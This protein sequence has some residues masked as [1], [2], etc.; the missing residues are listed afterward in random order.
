MRLAQVEFGKSGTTT[1]IHKGVF[2]IDFGDGLVA[3]HQKLDAAGRPSSNP[4]DHSRG[5]T[6]QQWLIPDLKP[7]Q[8]FTVVV[9]GYEI[10]ET[11]TEISKVKILRMSGS[12]VE[13]AF[14][15][16]TTSATS[17]A[18]N[19]LPLQEAPKKTTTPKVRP[20]TT[21]RRMKKGS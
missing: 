9:I 11:E 1:F 15:I 13:W 20:R 5:L 17:P 2:L 6:N 12:I 4:T 21:Q 8:D 19:A 10:D 16:Y 14:R 7:E 3:R 18:M